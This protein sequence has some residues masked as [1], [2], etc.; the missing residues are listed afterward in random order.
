MA[1]GPTM[2]QS[3]EVR[4]AYGSSPYPRITS[5]GLILFGQL[6]P[7]SKPMSTSSWYGGIL[8]WCGQLS[9]VSG[10]GIWSR[11][12]G[13]LSLVLSAQSRCIYHDVERP[14][15]YA[16]KCNNRRKM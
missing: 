1:T 12:E 16:A 2:L 14:S 15:C 3:S 8:A 7:M 5:I 10:L 6:Q 11:R 4:T 13:M 9:T